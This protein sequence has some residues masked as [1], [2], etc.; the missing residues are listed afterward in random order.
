[1]PAVGRS[2]VRRRLVI[3]EGVLSRGSIGWQVYSRFAQCARCGRRL[4][5]G[6]ALSP[7]NGVIP[8]PAWTLDVGCARGLAEFERKL[9]K[10]RTAEGSKRAQAR[11]VRLVASLRSLATKSSRP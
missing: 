10:A 4:A 3:G 9:I 8:P 7:I 1:M 6:S 5:Q 11:G 2:C